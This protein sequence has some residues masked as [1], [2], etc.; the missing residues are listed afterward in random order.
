MLAILMAFAMLIG[1]MSVMGSA[2]QAY[3]GAAIVNSY[4]D[5]DSP[6]FTL[7]QYAS[8]GLD[9]VDRMLAK[10]NLV[11]NIYI[12]TLDLA[13]INTTIQSVRQLLAS[14]QTLL[15]MLGDAASLDIHRLT[16]TGNTP[17]A[18]STANYT[19]N[20]TD[21]EVIYALLNMLADN[22]G[23][24]GKYVDG[25]INLGVMHSFIANYVFDVRELVIGLVYG[26][27]DDESDYDYFDEKNLDAVPAI[28]K[29]AND[30]AINLAQ[31]LLN[32][33]VLGK[34]T[35]LDEILED[36]YSYMLP[37]YYH[38]TIGSA[39]G[40]EVP[41][42]QYGKPVIDTANYDYYGWVHPDDWVT[43]GLGDA[44]RVAE[45]AAAPAPSF[46]KV[47]VNAGVLGYDFIEVLMQ[48]AFNNILVP[49]LNSQTRPWVRK[50]CGVN[51]LD[52]Y[53]RRT[54]QV[55]GEWVKNPDF[56]RDYEGEADY[57]PT[58][59]ADIFNINGKITKAV[60][61]N[62]RTLVQEF[63]NIL[64]VECGN[65]LK[66][67]VPVDGVTYSWSWTNGDNDVLFQNICSVARFVVC[68]TGDYFFPTSVETFPTA[69]QVN[70][71]SD[72]QIV[73]FIGRTLFNHF[74][75]WMYIDGTNQT[76][77]DVCY[78]AC[79][80]LAWQDIPQR[81]Y[82]KPV[83]SNYASDALYY[84][85]L[86]D[87]CLNILM[88]VAVY[89][90]NQSLDMVGAKSTTPVG[91]QGLLQYE[92]NYEKLA[93]QVACW[94]VTSYAA[95][96]DGNLN[97]NT[98]ISNA[99][100]GTTQFDN[101]VNAVTANQ[102]WADLDTIFDALLPIKTG[103]DPII[104]AEIAGQSYVVKSLLFDYI[105]AP[106]YN[107]N[108]TNFAKIFDKNPDGIF[109]H[110]D[111]VGIILQILGNVFDLLAPGVFNRSIETLD[112]LLVDEKLAE[113]ATDLV[114][115]LGTESFQSIRTGA[116]LQGR[117]TNIVATAL[118]V[119]CMVLGLSDDQSFEEMSIYMPTTLKAGQNTTFAVYNGSGG[120]NTGYKNRAGSFSQDALYT[121]KISS[122]V[123][124]AIANGTET[125]IQ[126]TGIAQNDTIAGGASLDL[127]LPGNYLTAGS[128]IKLD[129]YYIANGED[130]HSI[131]GDDTDLLCTTVYGYVGA[132][133]KDDD[134]IEIEEAVGSDGRTIKY[135][136]AIYISEHEKLS[137][138][139]GYNVRVQDIEN[140]N[141]TGTA[142]VSN[143]SGQA[144]AIQN[145]DSAA[146]QNMTGQK[147]LYF[148]APYKVGVAS[149]DK[150]YERQ[151]ME[152]RKD[153]NDEV[154]VDENDEPILF[155]TEGANVVAPG[156]YTLNTTLNVKGT[157]KTITTNVIVY[158]DHNLPSMFRSAV[159]ANRQETAYDT[160]INEA[161]TAWQNYQTALNNA[162]T[163]VLAPK[164]ST[165]F[166]AATK[167]AAFE[168]AA[169]ALEE[170]I[171]A[172]NEYA[173]PAGVDAI[174]TAVESI[175][176]LNNELIPITETVDGTQY[177]FYYE[178]SLDYDDEDYVYFGMRDFVPH[179]YKRY[180]NA[181]NDAMDLYYDSIAIVPAPFTDTDV[182]G[183]NFVPT[184]EQVLNRQNA[185]KS[186]AE[187]L[188]KMVPVGAI[189]AAY[190]LH[191]VNL[192]GSRLIALT[193]NNSKLSA[194]VS[195]YGN[196]DTSTAP[197]TPKSKEA[198]DR[199]VDFATLTVSAGTSARPSQVTEALGQLVYAY[200]NLVKSC[201]FTAL[202]AAITAANSACATE[203]AAGN[204]QTT[205]T[206]ESWAAFMDAYEEATELKGQEDSLGLSESNQEMIDRAAARLNAARA[207]LEAAA[208]GEPVWVLVQEDPDMFYDMDYNFS[209]V[210]QYDEDGY[211]E[212]YETTLADGTELDGIIVGVGCYMEQAEMEAIFPAESLENCHVAF[213]QNDQGYYGTGAGIQI[214]DDNNTVLATYGILLRGDTNG[215]G[216]Y[217]PSDYSE[218]LLA[219]SGAYDWE[220]SDP[221]DTFKA[222]AMDIGPN[223]PALEVSSSGATNLLLVASGSSTLDQET[224]ITS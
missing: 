203:I 206:A 45:G 185:L 50:L 80:Q 140:T 71:M 191:M 125:P 24:V 56:D 66:N 131:T 138:I 98:F 20:S 121:Y 210:P 103:N 117:G 92:N 97:L 182:Y 212:Y 124:K 28:Y 76:V 141:N 107:L 129:I 19:G 222:A 160:S 188:D 177:N 99:T 10:E 57:E 143:V 150:A 23:L 219:A 13:N 51:Y 122:V 70:A 46:T 93:I 52:K 218:A 183:E 91:A 165:N 40:A 34:W 94:A 114:K 83:R 157:N 18:R 196:V 65:I 127:T 205:Y 64:G 79:E 120:V 82:T 39:T 208:S 204:A 213:I 192:T 199:A 58:P 113:M 137:A 215:D 161:V 187:K 7:E 108:A 4:N 43:V 101:A 164:D 69:A 33:Y 220:W 87:A 75:D 197:Y 153:E 25:T 221:Y 49:V 112:G 2:Y 60:I 198:Y 216:E 166:N 85:A 136:K 115:S 81:T 128:I 130:G 123:C 109:A 11:L 105:L 62:G 145:P 38:F 186:A 211:V 6:T 54:I 31:A 89:N 35:K 67:N 176:G 139:E 217:N 22:A 167:G 74:V 119:I 63:N 96:I 170:A 146:Q 200:K 44:I 152:T 134:A 154:I 102:V 151:Y 3:K 95:V 223:G 15:P 100:V 135:E 32:K 189:D 195:A 84:A 106:L 190:G 26:L 55:N 88:D 14:V 90:L 48:Q 149:N 17:I 168:A 133:D 8:M 72:Q 224:G 148:F 37:E 36:E 169:D 207:A 78:A 5:V 132:T 180:R 147:G 155:P 202:T 159:S 12:G 174:E 171:E 47:D 173:L 175:S 111:G 144:F 178:K 9:E 116:N 201:D 16:K 110:K 29:G 42:D 68:V 41:T 1:S 209:F 158:Y 104:A 163:L 179:T 59:L 27:L 156:N 162:A 61:P 142:V 86:R 172:L 30:G 193:S 73:A 194:V 126:T 77:M 181:R 118:P 21:L 214:L 184:D 53:T